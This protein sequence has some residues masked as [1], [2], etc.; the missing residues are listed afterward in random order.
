MS[1]I[2]TNGAGQCDE[3]TEVCEQYVY[4]LAR[5]ALAYL[6]AERGYVSLREC[7]ADKQVRC[8]VEG[9]LGEVEVGLQKE[10]A[11]FEDLPR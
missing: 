4:D 6:G 1:L 9:A 10:G 7:A 5:L 11:V 3:A 2:V 8:I